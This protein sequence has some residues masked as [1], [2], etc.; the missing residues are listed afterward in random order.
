[1]LK[2][3]SKENC[4]KTGNILH[5]GKNTIRKMQK[6]TSSKIYDKINTK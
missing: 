3:E 4:T 1:M 2:R 5:L 6:Y